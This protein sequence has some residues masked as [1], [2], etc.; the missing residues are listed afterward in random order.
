MEGRGLVHH[1]AVYGSRLLM[2]GSFELVSKFH[3]S[4]CVKT[5]LVFSHNVH[6][7]FRHAKGTI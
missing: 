1:V 3:L 4:S 5:L 7:L 2:C 6:S